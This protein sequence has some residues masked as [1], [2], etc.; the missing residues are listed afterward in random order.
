M[1]P[2]VLL[3]LL[4]F[5]GFST[6]L[7]AQYRFSHPSNDPN[8]ELV[9]E[10]NFNG[11]SIN[12]SKW[13]FAPGWGNCASG[14]TISLDQNN[15]VVS[16]GI[17]TL[18]TK[19]DTTSCHMWEDTISPT[20]YDKFFSSGC[21][22]SKKAFKYG[23]F[24]IKSKFPIVN[25]QFGAKG[26]SPCFWLYP[27]KHWFNPMTQYSEIDVCEVRG[28][29]NNHTCN[30]HYS[31]LNHQSYYTYETI[32]PNIVDSS[33][34]PGWSMRTSGDTIYDFPVNDGAFHT[35]SAEWNYQAV[36]I[37]FDNMFIRKASDNS[38]FHAYNLLPLN[39]M[40]TN[41]ANSDNFGDII[42]NRTRL[43]YYYDIDYVKVYQLICD[44]STVVYNIPN[45]NT[46][47]YGVKKSITLTSA[48]TLPTNQSIY[49]R[50]KNFIKLQGGF[51]VPLGT[52]L[53]LIT[54]ICGDGII[55]DEN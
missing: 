51:E 10:E 9:W 23:F 5:L 20:Y 29:N 14:S 32:G 42:N 30:V 50:A 6:Y 15:H 4:C 45:F 39:I 28:V 27:V 52:S 24:E 18:V 38:I 21:L 22:Y 36:S 31:D 1:K 19:R 44:T 8:W 48:T 43:P 49:L 40:I 46:Y 37:Y 12:S 41:V 53:Y 55:Q 33:F 17:V 26:M 16:N 7:H 35:Y 54:C 3:T 34:H 25:R 47:T 2:Y 11:D 13:D